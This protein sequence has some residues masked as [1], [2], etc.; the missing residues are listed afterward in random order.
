MYESTLFSDPKIARTLFEVNYLSGM[1]EGS[2]LIINYS[3]IVSG[4]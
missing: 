4:Y 1:E 3:I 2:R